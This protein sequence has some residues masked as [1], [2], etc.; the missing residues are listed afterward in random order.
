MTPL[1]TVEDAL[2]LTLVMSRIVALMM[3]F[4]FFNTNMIP[5]NVKVLLVVALSFF[6]MKV[7]GTHVSIQ[8][9]SLA[10]FTLLIFKELLIGFAL[11]LLAN[12]FIAAFSYAAEIISYFMGLTIVNSFDPTYGQISILS[13]FFIML[14]YLIFFVSGAYQYFFASLI[15][16]LQTI[17]LDQLYF[18]QG[19]WRFIVELSKE[20]FTLA[21]KLAFPFALILYMVNLALALVN[22]L[23]PQINVFIV[24]LPLQI[25]VGLAALAFGASVV[26]YTGSSFLAKMVDEYLFVLKSLG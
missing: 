1:V 6:L 9:F 14:F 16:S 12:I 25:F 11:G 13:R 15:Q 5:L 3:A 26:V 22:R 10:T 18:N 4:P 2:T 24:G 8:N 21:F 19:L 17:P 23:I 7:S 20:L